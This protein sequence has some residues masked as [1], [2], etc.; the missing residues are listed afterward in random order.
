MKT[1]ITK[2]FLVLIFANLLFISCQETSTHKEPQYNGPPKGKII[3]VAQ[4]QNMYKTYTERRV[5]IIQKFEDSIDKQDEKF[6]PTRYAEYDLETIKQYIAYIEHEA[7]GAKVDIKT[8]RFYLS[9]YPASDKFSDGKAVKY[10]RRNSFFILP[11]MAYEGNNVGFSIENMDGKRV[12]VPINKN[13]GKT[14]NI[15]GES[16]DSSNQMNEAG[17]FTSNNSAVQKSTSLIINDGQL[18]PPPGD[19]DFGNSN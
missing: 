14:K 2:R 17:F 13:F 18:I 7:K 1:K 19:D 10:P 11:T 15:D 4:A 8:L 9:T 3:S 12:A 6:L 16:D 5:P